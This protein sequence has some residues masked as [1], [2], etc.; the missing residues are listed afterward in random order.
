MTEDSLA[1]IKFEKDIA[2]A[3]IRPKLQKVCNTLGPIQNKAELRKKFIEQ[4]GVAMSA[5]KFEGYLTM[6]DITFVKTV[7]IKGLFT[8]A[9]PPAVA[10]A[11]AS[12]EEVAF[13]NEDVSPH[14][15]ASQQRRNDMFNQA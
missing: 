12:E 1:T 5:A 6:L 7:E 2:E 4:E 9:P 13:D 11:D 3:V 8:D 14:R 15:F 10:G